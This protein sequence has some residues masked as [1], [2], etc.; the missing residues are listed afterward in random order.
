M[1]SEYDFVFFCGLR[2]YAVSVRVW[3]CDEG[4][5]LP[6]LPGLVIPQTI[7]RPATQSLW[8]EFLWAASACL[9]LEVLPQ[10]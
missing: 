10:M 8:K 7:F 9:D 2:R 4:F 1:T 5:D 6:V 3:S